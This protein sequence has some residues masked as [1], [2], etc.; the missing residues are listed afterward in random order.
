M[1]GRASKSPVGSKKSKGF[2]VSLEDFLVQHI[3]D[4]IGFYRSRPIV[5]STSKFDVV[6]R[7]LDPSG[8]FFQSFRIDGTLLGRAE[9]HS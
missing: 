6:V 1:Q 5:S 7:A 2:H 4:I 8:G 9:R 3:K